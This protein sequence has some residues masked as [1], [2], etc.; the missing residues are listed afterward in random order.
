MYANTYINP[1][2]FFA[3]QIKQSQS[4]ALFSGFYFSFK[5]ANKKKE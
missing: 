1:F 3:A 2:I 5:R 4:L